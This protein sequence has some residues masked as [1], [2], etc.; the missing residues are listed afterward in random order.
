MGNQGTFTKNFKQMI[1]DA[2]LLYH[3]AYVAFCLLGLCMHPFF[4]S[5]LVSTPNE[6]EVHCVFILAFT[7]I[8]MF[9]S[10]VLNV[11]VT[12]VYYI[13]KKNHRKKLRNCDKNK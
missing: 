3:S 8:K 5:V 10:L 9:V 2:E 7:R 6:L 11:P 13:V 1:T 12:A 4:Y